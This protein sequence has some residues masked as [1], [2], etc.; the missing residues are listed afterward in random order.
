MNRV[1][2]SHSIYY[3]H[4]KLI[5]GTQQ[6]V[7][8]YEFLKGEFPD[9]KIICPHITV[10]ELKDP[11]DYLHIVDCCILLIAS[12]L[13]GFIG[14]GVFVEVARAFSNNA[15]VFVLRKHKNSFKLLQVIGIEIYN[16]IDWKTK[17]AKLIVKK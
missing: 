1:K 10:G 8:E 4:S 3:A 5:Y 2:N 12:E 6:E 17:Y 14:L 11:Q 15:H 7:E 13:N 9:R 16:Q